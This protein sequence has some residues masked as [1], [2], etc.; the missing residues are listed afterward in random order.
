VDALP[1]DR[2][3]IWTGS[4]L[5][6]ARRPPEFLNRVDERGVLTHLVGRVRAAQS[7]VL[8][9]RG[10]AGCGKTA[11]LMQLS[12]AANGSRVIWATG[13]ESEME[14]AFAGLHAL[15]TPLLDRL[16]RLP[17]PQHEALSTAFGL[18]AGPPPERF[19]VGLA[20][21]SLL[22]DAAEEQPIVCVVDDAP[23]LDRMSSADWCSR[24]VNKAAK[25]CS[26]G[27]RSW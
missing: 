17:Q 8:V 18:S 26:T 15:C 21:L 7:Q 24:Y 4:M 25:R 3:A 27:C 19:L 2:L 13:V 14:L 10:E 9:V 11:L 5:N 12:E 16:G 22:A 23:W 6:A 1:V 20:V